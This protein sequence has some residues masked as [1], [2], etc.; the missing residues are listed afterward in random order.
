M[1]IDEGLY[2]EIVRSVPILCVDL[3]IRN[4]Q[5]EFLLVR[6]RNE[7]LLGHFYIPGGRVLLGETYAQAATRK[8]KQ[9]TNLTPDEPL[10]L[11]GIYEDQFDKSSFGTHPYQTLSLVYTIKLNTVAQRIKLDEQS[12]D[13]KFSR[14][15]PLRLNEKI[16]WIKL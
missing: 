5:E 10:T 13:W 9:E 12:S 11:V 7:P 8:L 14:D 6:R 2:K 3:L 15:L 4:E 16:N 1:N